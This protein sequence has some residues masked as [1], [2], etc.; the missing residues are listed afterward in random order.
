M[1]FKIILYCTRIT[2]PY[3]EKILK[4]KKNK[5][6]I[7]QFWNTHPIPTHTITTNKHTYT[8]LKVRSEATI[9]SVPLIGWIT[10][11]VSGTR[12]E[13]GLG[14]FKTGSPSSLCSLKALVRNIRA[15]LGNAGGEKR[16]CSRTK[17]WSSEP[18]SAH[19][20]KY[21]KSFIKE[22]DSWLGDQN[23]SCTLS[24]RTWKKA[25]FPW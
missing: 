10:A 24:E 21:P 22:M 14:T 6:F 8:C 23:E 15:L 18:F 17:K 13:V 20:S 3:L 16:L 25:V 4:N 9:L 5:S 2:S 11:S 7:I 12:A 19:R 1:Y